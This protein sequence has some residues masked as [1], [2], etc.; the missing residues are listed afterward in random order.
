MLQSYYAAVI[1]GAESDKSWG[2][3]C[4]PFEMGSLLK[5]Q[6]TYRFSNVNFSILI[7]Y[8]LAIVL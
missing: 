1:I 4:K 7:I 8:T 5:G 3:K 6:K 2:S